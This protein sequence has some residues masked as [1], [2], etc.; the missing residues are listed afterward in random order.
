MQRH[1]GSWAEEDDKS[2]CFHLKILCKLDENSLTEHEDE[3][4]KNEAIR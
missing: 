1:M 3:K 4:T 2:T